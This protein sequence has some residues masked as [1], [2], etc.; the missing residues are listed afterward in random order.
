MRSARNPR[1]KGEARE[2]EA[3][4]LQDRYYAGSSVRNLVESS[5]WSFGTVHN[6][7][8]EVDTVM[9]KQG[10]QPRLR[11]AAAAEPAPQ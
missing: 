11:P 6:L 10:G 3:L 4:R 7:L 2:K 1:L 8:A 9:R 5:G